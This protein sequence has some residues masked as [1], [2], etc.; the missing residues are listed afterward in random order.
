MA[1]RNTIQKEI[2]EIRDKLNLPYHFPFEDQ[3]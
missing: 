2:I 1:D 3:K